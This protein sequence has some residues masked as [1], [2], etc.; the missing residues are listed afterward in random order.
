MKRSLEQSGG[1][2]GS[3]YELR[4]NK[5]RR[6]NYFKKEC[7]GLLAAHD[8]LTLIFQKMC[9]VRWM[10]EWFNGKILI[11]QSRFEYD[12][13]FRI[14]DTRFDDEDVF[15]REFVYTGD[16]VNVV[17]HTWHMYL[18]KITDLKAQAN[19][20][21]NLTIQSCTYWS[22][23]RESVHTWDS[24]HQSNFVLHDSISSEDEYEVDN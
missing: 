8:V 7:F 22:R 16:R 3:E 9:Q 14:T 23:A 4:N 19:I 18:R 1:A 20:S 15:Q 17:F 5:V 10:D 2:P 24:Y 6:V 21:R 12:E 13:M 11:M